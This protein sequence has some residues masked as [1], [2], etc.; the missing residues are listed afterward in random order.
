[1]PC[2]SIHPQL[3][4]IETNTYRWK[5]M[6]RNRGRKSSFESPASKEI[7]YRWKG[8]GWD[9]RRKS[10]FERITIQIKDGAMEEESP[11]CVKHSRLP[12]SLSSANQVDAPHQW[13][14]AC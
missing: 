1:M 9:G 12:S 8:K 10:N 5:I 4:T 6:G 14:P 13:Q 3:F 2:G 7:L 11:G